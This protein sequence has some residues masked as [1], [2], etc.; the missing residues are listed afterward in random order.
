MN[1]YMTVHKSKLMG[2]GSKIVSF[3][4]Y[5]SFH[6]FPFF[7][8]FILQ[9]VFEEVHGTVLN[10]EEALMKPL[11]TEEFFFLLQLFHTVPSTIVPFLSPPLIRDPWEMVPS[12]IEEHWGGS[13][14]VRADSESKWKSYFLGTQGHQQLCSNNSS[15]SIWQK[16]N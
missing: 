4:A 8:S 16:K 3:I 6:A 11:Y 10:S 1:Y 13:L 9:S 7:L 5:L 14:G 15:T 2:V 12:R